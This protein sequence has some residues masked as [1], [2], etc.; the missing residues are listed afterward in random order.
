MNDEEVVEG[1]N[2]APVTAA[3]LSGGEIVVMGDVLTIVCDLSARSGICA[4]ISPHS[5]R[6]V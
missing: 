5:H 4:D 2:S 1:F 3:T 6:L